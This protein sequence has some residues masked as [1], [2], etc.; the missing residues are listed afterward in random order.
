LALT[1]GQ[2]AVL[3]PLIGEVKRFHAANDLL[4]Q[5]VAAA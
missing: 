3:E 2:W 4:P 1:D 5:V